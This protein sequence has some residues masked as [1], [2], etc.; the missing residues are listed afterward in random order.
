LAGQ[1]R[2][3]N[4]FWHLF[5]SRFEKVKP[6]AACGK[7]NPTRILPALTPEVHRRQLKLWKPLRALPH[8]T[9]QRQPVQLS[10]AR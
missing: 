10:V 3:F 8:L 9:P 5:A 6:A 4:F 7:N 2:L 1:F